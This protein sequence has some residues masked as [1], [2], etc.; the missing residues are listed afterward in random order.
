MRICSCTITNVTAVKSAIHESRKSG[1]VVNGAILFP[2][3]L[4]QA[5]AVKITGLCALAC[6]HIPE[7]GFKMHRSLQIYLE[8]T[9]MGKRSRSFWVETHVIVVSL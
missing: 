2:R 1:H 6:K 7:K 4:M 8:R 5:I 3:L 9:Y